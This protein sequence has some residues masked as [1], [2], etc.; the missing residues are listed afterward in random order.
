MEQTESGIFKKDPS[1]IIIF[2]V[3]LL[4]ETGYDKF[5]DK[6]I[7]VWSNRSTAVDRLSRKGFPAG[8]ALK[9]F[10]AQMPITK[11]KALAD[12]VIEN[13][14]SLTKTEKRVNTIYQ[15]ICKDSLT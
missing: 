3:P 14:H 11:K 8:D 1:A 2:E 6:T 12:F 4:F 13:N 10:R 15:A 7:V 9:R 5:F